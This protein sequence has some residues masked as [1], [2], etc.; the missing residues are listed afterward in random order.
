[1]NRVINTCVSLPLSPLSLSLPPALP[2]TFSTVDITVG[3][4]VTD[5]R[6]LSNTRGLRPRIKD[7]NGA[8][9]YGTCV[10][11]ETS[12]TTQWAIKYAQG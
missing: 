7:Y 1:M 2:A 6:R 4:W 12:R 5:K 8:P 3:A 9:T 10:R 11:T